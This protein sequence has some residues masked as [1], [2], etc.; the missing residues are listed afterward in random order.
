MYSWKSRKQPLLGI[1]ITSAAVKLLEL[2][3]DG[4]RHRVESY[5]V[6]PLPQEEGVERTAPGVEAIANAVR[7]ALK[8]SNTKLRQAA[9]AVS[10]SAVITKIITVA[11]NLDERAIEDQIQVEADQYIPYNLD[12]VSIDFDVLG[13]SESKPGMQDVLL[14]ACRKESIDDRV[15]ALGIAGIKT[16]I[17]DVEA[18]ASLNALDLLIDQFPIPL[19]RQHNIAFVDIG[20]LAT[21]LSICRNGRIIYSRE[22]DFG[23]KHLR[24]EIQ[25]HYGLTY[26]EAGLAKKHGALPNFEKEIL[27]PFKQAVAQMISRSLQFFYSSSEFR[28]VDCI[29]LAGGCAAIGGIDTL[30]EEML[31]TPSFVA[32]PFI[33]M[34]LSPRIKPQL[35]GNDAP[36]MM[37]ACGLAL[38]S[39]Q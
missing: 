7:T 13:L 23:G 15:A 34:T 18:Y 32:N 29:V 38:R 3:H 19:S 22:Q 6:A 10:G 27:D 1:D 33:N 20:S 36:A 8:L 37:T 39:F 25:R 14:A 2:S 5:A 30:A 21:K 4:T 11:A 9:I 24:E 26:E 12:E 31:G 35:L 28:G 16:R 17:V